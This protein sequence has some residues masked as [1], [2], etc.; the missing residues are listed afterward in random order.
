MNAAIS[1]LEEM[2]AE[3]TIGTDRARGGSG[4]SAGGHSPAEA[5]LRRA[6]AY[7]MRARAGRRAIERAETDALIP[8][9]PAEPKRPVSPEAASFLRALLTDSSPNEA[10]L[11]EWAKRCC[12]AGCVAPPSL[13]PGLLA[14][15][16]GRADRSANVWQAMGVRG[17]WLASLNTDWRKPVAAA[18]IPENLEERWDTGTVPERVALLETVRPLDASRGLALVLRTWG[19]EPAATRDKFV[20]ALMD[21]RCLGDEEFLEAALDDRSAGVRSS[22]ALILGLLPGSKLR[23]RC[24]ERA[25][26]ILQVTTERSGLLRRKKAKLTIALPT[27]FDPAWA[28]DGIQEKTAEAKGQRMYWT[29]QILQRTDVQSWL[30]HTGLAFGELISALSDDDSFGSV[31]PSLSR[32]AMGTSN[33][34]W[35]D[36]LF[37]IYLSGPETDWQACMNLCRG[38][39]RQSQEAFMLRIVAHGHSDP[40]IP[41]QVLACERHEWSEEFWRSAVEVLA[42][43][44]FGNFVREWELRHACRGICE[45]I[46]P[47]AAGLLA[48]LLSRPEPGAEPTAAHPASTPETLERLRLRIEL[49]KLSFASSTA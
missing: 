49:H 20:M 21:E 38:L 17:E 22:A 42:K 9:C 13:V 27:K 35:V 32:S 18:T 47:G 15:W 16:A 37:T 11:E 48:D 34:E 26:A 30:D 25:K 19:S 14:W 29:T 40:H 43:T 39:N 3:A 23:A 4:H 7:G 8:P 44:R 36:E 10:L 5:L 1:Q 12:D 46:H 33:V 45:F 41:W 2:I 24:A 31:F 28:R 6:A